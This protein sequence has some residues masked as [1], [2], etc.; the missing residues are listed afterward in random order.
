MRRFFIDQPLSSL[1]LVITGADAHHISHV[2]RLMPGDK[3][4]LIAP[5]EEVGIAVITSM[6]KEAVRLNLQ[7]KIVEEREAPLHITLVQGLPKSDKMD[8]IVQKTVELGVCEIIP[9]AAEH[10]VVKYDDHKKLDRVK[11]WQKIASEA[12]KQC[13]RTIMP[14]VESVQN[15][16]EILAGLADDTVIIMLYEGEVSI[17]LKQTLHACKA[18][19]YVLLIGPEGG[20]SPE[21][22][23]LCK[24]HK[25][26]VVTLGPRI[27]RT[28]TAAVAAVALL[29]YE[30]G[31]LG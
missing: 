3:V 28:E 16:A 29:M 14:V 7:E 2:L 30:C 20:F 31:D 23:F 18:S 10:S 8:Y 19:K 25:A 1:P 9:L 5:Q 27:L 26:Q 12:A 21:E 6:E 17:G 15:L 4:T 24:A 11:R 22:V 13:K